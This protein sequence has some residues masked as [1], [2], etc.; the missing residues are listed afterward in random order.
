MAEIKQNANNEWVMT[1]NIEFDPIVSEPTG[2]VNRT[3][4]AISFDDATRTFTIQPTISE[5]SYY[6]QE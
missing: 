5:Y 2:F 4:S 1:G 3:D 6:I